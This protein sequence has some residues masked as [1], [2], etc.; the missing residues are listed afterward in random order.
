MLCQSFF[1]IDIYVRYRLKMDVEG[2]EKKE[3]E[4]VEEE[5]E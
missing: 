1:N 5:E 3:T 2:E 4:E